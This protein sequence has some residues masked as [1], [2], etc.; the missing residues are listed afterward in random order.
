MHDVNLRLFIAFELSEEIR[1]A[2]GEYMQPLRALPGKVSWVKP[3]NI[4]LTIK[5]LGD[6]PE[7]RIDEITAS[8]R[9]IAA[10][11]RAI[12]AEVSGSG[13]FPNERRP[14]IVWI[15][16]EEKSGRLQGL[17]SAINDRMHA[18]GFEK[19][20][21]RFS[22]H[23]TI[24]RVREGAID[25]IIRQMQAQSFAKQDVQ[26]NEITLMRSELRPGGSIYTP[27]GKFK[28]GNS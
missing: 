24:G 11:N 21:R 12:D 15:G 22:P 3:D 6:A 14:R 5:F 10:I 18:L 7:K 27:L 19:E 16:L 1:I 17:A 13:V 8:L 26:F 23:L 2:L 4:H 28:L 20:Q 9:E 25:K